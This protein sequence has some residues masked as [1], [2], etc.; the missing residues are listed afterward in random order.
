MAKAEDPPP[1]NDVFR[2]RGNPEMRRRLFK[3]RRRVAFHVNWIL[4]WS[5]LADGRPETSRQDSPKGALVSRGARPGGAGG[6]APAGPEGRAGRGPWKAESRGPR[7]CRGRC[8]EPLPRR[9]RRWRP[10]EGQ[11]SPDPSDRECPAAGQGT[12]RAGDPR[13]A[14]G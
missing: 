8:R 3:A 4:Q 2:F 6:P 14:P 9:R 13:Y 1:P 10:A 5:K 11:R 12:V 7:R